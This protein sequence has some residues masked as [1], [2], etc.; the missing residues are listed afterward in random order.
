MLVNQR[1]IYQ[2]RIHSFQNSL[3]ANGLFAALIQKPR[4]LYY[5]AGT[6]QPGNLWIPMDG[7]PILFNRRAFEMVLQESSIQNIQRGSGFKEIFE[8]LRECEM[9]PPANT[10][11]GV[12]SDFIPYDIIKKSKQIFSESTFSNVTKLI[13]DQRFI[14][15]E[16]E[17]GK[18]RTAAKLW[19]KSHEAILQ[20][21]SP[22]KKE[23]KM[24]PGE[25]A[26]MV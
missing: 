13:M 20:L 2:E 16:E 18:I 23:L 21:A 25:M 22:G 19:T 14:K 24:R 4:N 17:I 5:Y 1:T 26:E 7:E 11:I 6:S 9:L 8:Y 3:K 10:Y 12:E 15:T